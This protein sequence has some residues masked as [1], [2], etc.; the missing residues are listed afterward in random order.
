LA[1]SNLASSL[2]GVPE[3]LLSRGVGLSNTRERLEQLYGDGQSLRLFNLEPK[4]VCVQV[5]IPR[6]RL[7]SDE[8]VL[9]R[10]ATA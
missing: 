6:R 8:K 1:V 2:E 5:S 3:E 4:G 9:A 7:P 10:V